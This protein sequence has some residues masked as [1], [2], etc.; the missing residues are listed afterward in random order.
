MAKVI[1]A[2]LRLKD[3]FSSTLKVAEKNL[4]GFES[5]AK[6]MGDSFYKTS[7]GLDNLSKK[8]MPLTVGAVGAVGASVAAFGDF[9][10]AL[11]GVSKT[12]DLTD[13]EFQKLSDD[14]VAMTREIPTSATEIAGVAEAAGQLGIEKENIL[15]FTETMVM[16]GTAT[17]M[18]SDEA[19]SMAAKFANITGMN[20]KDFDKLGSTIV[21]LGNNS[22][23][24]ERDIM[25][26][27]MRLA[28]AGAQVGMTE[29]EI[30]GMSAALSSVGIEAEAGGSAMSKV[31]IN[32]ASAA[33][34]GGEELD[35]FAEVTG[36][37]A[38]GFAELFKSD[39]T[40]ALDEFI[41]A[42]GN[43]EEQG[44]SAIGILDEMG[45]TEVRLRDTLLRAAGASELFSD[46][47]YMGNDAWEENTALADEAAEAY[48]S[49]QNSIQYLKNTLFEVGQVI[50]KNVMPII[51][52]VVDKIT[53]MAKRF[54]D[55]DKETQEFILKMVALAAAIAPTL[56]VLSL[57]TGGIGKVFDKLKLVS[58]ALKTGKSLFGAIATPGMQFVLVIGLIIGAIVLLVKYWDQI[59][60]KAEEIFPGI[61]ETF[62]NMAS[63]IGE[64]I[65]WIV[66]WANQTFLDFMEG[67]RNTWAMLEPIIMPVIEGIIGLIDNLLTALDGIIEFLVGVFLLDWE[68]VW[69]GAVKIFE[70]IFGGI[71]AIGKGIINGMIEIIN[72]GIRSLNKIKV[73]DFI[74]IF[75]G[76]GVNIPEIP[77]LYT[78]TQNWQGGF[79]EVNDRGGEII[80]LPKGSRVIP[81]DES[82]KEAYK[83]GQRHT[84][85]D[86]HLTVAKL[87]E[88]LI[89]REEADID[90]I[91]EKLYKK[92]EV[93][94]KNRVKAGAY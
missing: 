92:I 52:P 1:D 29:A 16:M 44:K 56:K 33:E 36:Y 94:K 42:L 23:T 17:N 30:L 2:V 55:S 27:A 72:G 68:K 57:L 82:V 87:A 22:A 79:A 43:A 19:A 41:S 91:I 67:M 4:K 35:K 32:M 11:K 28:G 20:Q 6:Y 25:T 7:K 73:P 3:D 34:L 85:G 40:M 71:K 37:T 58:G 38:D 49:F 78:G 63:N 76:K 62:S 48:S 46:T 50:A 64:V 88:T 83:M 81:H 86:T 8:F 24:T 89:V 69:S 61:S 47:I 51:G 70:G 65:S 59:K 5:Q 74:P 54:V 93:A 15:G 12:T 9:E 45:M 75:G 13:E 66:D 14:I 31:M 60:A 53:E 80:D 21:E 39:P 77:Q 90:K 26:M 10:T 84:G 18:A